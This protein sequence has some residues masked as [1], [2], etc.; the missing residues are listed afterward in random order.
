MSRRKY[1]VLTRTKKVKTIIGQNVQYKHH[2]IK[3]CVN[4]RDTNDIRYKTQNNDKQN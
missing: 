1:N 3:P 4:A 2:Y